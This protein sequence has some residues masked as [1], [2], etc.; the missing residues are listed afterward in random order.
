MFVGRIFIVVYNVSEA[1]KKKRIQQC[2]NCLFVQ[3]KIKLKLQPVIWSH[4][5]YMVMRVHRY[6]IH[7]HN[8]ALWHGMAWHGYEK[9]VILT[10]SSIS[11][12]ASISLIW[13]GWTMPEPVFVCFVFVP[14]LENGY[15]RSEN[16]YIALLTKLICNYSVH[17]KI[18]WF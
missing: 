9:V 11:P 3:K 1:R 10:S 15:F 8:T 18:N 13:V 17:T 5:K 12:R 7:S 6:I 4:D 2:I 16:H 14:D